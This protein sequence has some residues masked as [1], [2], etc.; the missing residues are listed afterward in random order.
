MQ[1]SLYFIN[2]KAKMITK[3]QAIK[4]TKSIKNK[5]FFIDTPR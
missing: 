4:A 5:F 3:I 2:P 1:I